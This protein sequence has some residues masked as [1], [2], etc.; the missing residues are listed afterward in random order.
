MSE[1]QNKPSTSV[2]VLQKS[3]D[4]GSARCDDPMSAPTV[5]DAQSN[6]L[7]TK[8]NTQSHYFHS[9]LLGSNIMADDDRLDE[10]SS[11]SSIHVHLDRLTPSSGVNLRKLV[12]F[13]IVRHLFALNCQRYCL[14]RCPVWHRPRR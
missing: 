2:A 4:L 7:N 12:T 14:Y 6:V 8:S 3:A 5:L 11:I 10:M 13:A 1:P 9:R